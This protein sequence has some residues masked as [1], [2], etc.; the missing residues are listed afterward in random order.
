MKES[1]ILQPLLKSA[2]LLK[3]KLEGECSIK[4]ERK[5]L[6]SEKQRQEDEKF[7]GILR[8]SHFEAS[9]AYRSLCLS[10]PHTPNLQEKRKW[11][12]SCFLQQLPISS[13]VSHPHS[14]H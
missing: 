7:E 12:D 14:A 6:R 4:R 2:L 13:S 11:R 5:D 9:Q 3:L 1:E 10:P 8:Y